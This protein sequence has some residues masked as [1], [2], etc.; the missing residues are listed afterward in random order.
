MRTVSRWSN[1]GVGTSLSQEYILKNWSGEVSSHTVG[2]CRWENFSAGWGN[3]GQTSGYGLIRAIC[4]AFLHAVLLR[5]Y[6]SGP[7]CANADALLDQFQRF[8]ASAV[9][10]NVGVT[11]IAA[12]VELLMDPGCLIPSSAQL[13]VVRLQPPTSLKDRH[14]RVIPT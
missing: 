2:Q 4:S 13:Q 12:M 5:D 3:T 1:L 11:L 6:I 10:V 8:T 7:S 14:T 9:E